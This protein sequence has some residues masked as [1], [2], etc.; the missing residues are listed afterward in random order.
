MKIRARRG[1][2]ASSKPIIAGLRQ[3][4]GSGIPAWAFGLALSLCGLVL[5][6]SATWEPNQPRQLLFPA[7][8]YFSPEFLKQSV[9]LLVAIGLYSLVRRLK[10]GIRPETWLW[11]YAPAMF[12]LL[13]VVILGHGLETHG[14][15][16]WL[17]LGFF[18]LQ[19]SELAKAAW[20]LILAWFFASPDASTGRA[21]WRALA[22]MGSMIVFIM[23]QPDLGTSLVFIF[24]FFATSLLARTPRQAILLT[25]AGF[26][27][28]SVP[29]WLLMK[30]YQKNRL[31]AFVGKEL[32]TGEDADPEYGWLR[33]AS[34]RGANYQIS[35]S[36][37]AVGSGAFLGKGFLRGTQIRGGF[38]PVAE[39]DFIYALI[40]EEFGLAGG[41]FV[42]SLYFLLLMHILALARSAHSEYERLLCLGISAVLLFHVFVG[43][44]MTIRVTPVTGVPLPFISKGGSALLTFW[45][46]LAMLDSLQLGRQHGVLRERALPRILK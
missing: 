7:G 16:R 13:L 46:C 35:Q 44:G 33:P 17:D 37:I 24:A 9:A 14:S 21:H 29:G 41:L 31:L 4:A 28:L 36:I 34:P 10:W 22:V 30:D 23:L 2:V 3:L 1:I 38:V 27:L 25:A 8:W 11:W 45:L 40:G 39:S 15:Q 5:V 20:V 18:K 19:P 26:L 43:V 12:L 6:Y 32:N 42:L